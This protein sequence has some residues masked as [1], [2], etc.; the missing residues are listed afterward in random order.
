MFEI[1]RA[2][3]PIDAEAVLNIWREFV[4]SPSVCLDYQENETEFAS[5]PGK[6]DSPGGCIFLADRQEYIGGCIAFRRVSQTICEMKR[7]YVR[8][9]ARGEGL[10][11]RLVQRLIDEAREAGYREMRLDVLAEFEQAERI[12]G[13]FGFVP[14]EPVSFNP[15]PGTRFLGLVL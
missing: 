6:Y 14:A 2:S 12:Y 3:F 5:L 7:L 13:R 4:A 8:P 10:G 15:L 9:H 1:R 11:C